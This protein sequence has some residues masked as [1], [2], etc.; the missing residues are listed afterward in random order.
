MKI[1]NLIVCGFRGFN[2]AC[3]PIEFHDDLTLLSGPNSY[4]KTSISEALEWLLFGITSKVEDAG[5]KAEYKGSYRNC[6]FPKSETPFVQATF[7]KG[8]GSEVVC[9][10]ELI[11]DDG[12]QKLLDGAGIPAWPWEQDAVL[13]PRPFVLQHSLKNLLLTTPTRRYEGFTRMIGAEE[14]N[15]FQGHFTSLCTKYDPHIPQAV[16]DLRDALSSFEARLF[17]LPSLASISR[18][19]KKGL[20]DLP[21]L[22]G[23]VIAECRKRIPDGKTAEED[24]LQRIKQLRQDA[25]SKVFDRRITLSDYSEQDRQSIAVD[26]SF[27]A[28]AITHE[29]TGRYM[30]LLKL[31]TI[32]HIIDRERF[33]KL[34]LP[35]LEQDPDGCPFCGQFLDEE[36]RGKIDATHKAL[37][38]EIATQDAIQK[39]RAEILQ[40]L[41]DIRQRL[42][43]YHVRHTGRVTALLSLKRE[44][45]M[46][47]LSAVL[48]P[49]H[50]EHYLAV[51]VAVQVMEAEVAMLEVA[52][53]EALESL[54]R[55]TDSIDRSAEEAK[56]TEE[57]G[58]TLFK[59]LAVARSYAEVLSNH[60]PAMSAADQA[61]EHELDVQA[62][63]EDLGVLIELMERRQEIAKDFRVQGILGNLKELRAAV[64]EY[65]A[66]KLRD[67]VERQLT[68]DVMAWYEQI[69]TPGD[70]DVHFSGFDLPTTQKGT[71]KDRQI[72]VKAT[73]YDVALASAVSSLSESKL[74]A[75][76][77]CM[78]IA[79][80]LKGCS[81]FDF[82][83][84][85]DPIQSLDRGHAA[86]LIGVIRKLVEEKEKQVVL[87]SH[88]HDWLKDVRKE[89]RT[90]NGYYYEITSYRQS[91]PVFRRC[92]WA[93]I[94][95]RRDEIQAI[96]NRPDA[97]AMDR[98]RAEEEFRLLFN[99]LAA[100]IY[101][102]KT[103][104]VR[105]ADRLNGGDVRAML[106]E[107]GMPVIEV[108]KI[109]A[110]YADVATAHHATAYDPPAE[111]LCKY[112]DLAA[113]M[114]KYLSQ[115]NAAATLE[116]A[117]SRIARM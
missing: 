97:S 94:K 95:E 38:H 57:L 74:N 78:N 24:I 1:K 53:K 71:T 58:T 98:Q 99:E 6:H 75:L 68:D 30:D 13:D 7:V 12:I 91:G 84:V 29:F 101:R 72:E 48:V 100:D 56:I 96:L 92:P 108:D 8:D 104:K 66:D 63:T 93:V 77:L 52:Y 79:N 67:L 59:Y 25:V 17:N 16:K 117:E 32:Q 28:D 40:E 41:R 88:D 82:L 116:N 42:A 37:E 54:M 64:G 103:S 11:G 4:G 90:L 26:E 39:R 10:G 85:D 15:D 21:K 109:S 80:N 49:V 61:L 5:S 14:L 73:S 112:L 89:C 36:K 23:A 47:Q 19:Y 55:V 110:A 105:N 46:A 113:Y 70:P 44:G 50:E 102:A 18:L 43:T 2:E 60:A 86:R 106:V 27:L 33:L 87:L 31:A 22:H 114:E 62:G 20:S 9:R 81:T 34:G 111:K 3:P 115:A 69:K 76:G 65:V 35:F 107:C 45:T 51:D 83:I